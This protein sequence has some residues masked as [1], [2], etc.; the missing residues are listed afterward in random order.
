VPKPINAPILLKYM[1]GSEFIKLSFK[2]FATLT[3][4]KENL[5]NRIS[6]YVM[7]MKIRYDLKKN[8]NITLSEYNTS[9]HKM[10]VGLKIVLWVAVIVL[11]LMLAILIIFGGQKT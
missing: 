8:P 2:E 10:S 3:R 1:K 9:K 7:K 5:R 6:F 11:V 4:E